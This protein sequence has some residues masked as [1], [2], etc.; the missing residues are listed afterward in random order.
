MEGE[1]SVAYDEYVAISTIKCM[2][3]FGRKT[4]REKTTRKT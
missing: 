3:N 4:W 2:Q 1:L